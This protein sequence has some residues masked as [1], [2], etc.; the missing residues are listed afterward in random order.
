[1]KNNDFEYGMNLFSFLGGDNSQTLPMENVEITNTLGEEKENLAKTNVSKAENKPAAKSSKKKEKDSVTMV[2]LPI[3]CYGRNWKHT[4]EGTEKIA[5]EK[6]LESL[7]T[8]NYEEVIANLEIVVLS[9]AIYFLYPEQ[10]T[11]SDVQ[12]LFNGQFNVCDGLMQM[13]LSLEDFPDMVAEEISL[14]TIAEKFGRSFPYYE[15][16]GLY[17]DNHAQVAIPVF[18]RKKNP[19]EFVKLPCE[20]SLFGERVELSEEQFPFFD[21]KEG[22]PV[23]EIISYVLG[24]AP[25]ELLP[26]LY[27]VQD[28][29]YVITLT[30]GKK[31]T[32]STVSREGFWKNG[33]DVTLVKAKELIAL[34]CNLYFVTLN[35]TLSLTSSV[36]GGKTK[37]E[38]QEI[39]DYLKSF[40]S[41]LRS[42]DRKIEFIYAKEQNLVSIAL[43]SGT[44]GMEEELKACKLTDSLTLFVDS[45]GR[46]RKRVE[47][48]LLGTFTT[49]Y[50]E[51]PTVSLDYTLPLIPNDL[52]KEIIKEFSSTLERERIVQILWDKESGYSL[53]Y[54]R[55]EIASKVR[56]NYHFSV[57]PE[58]VVVATIHSHT[59][60]AA[61]FSKVDDR[62]ERYTGIFG[63]L[64][65]L[66]KKPTWT[67]RVGMEGY[68]S[69][70]DASQII[71]MKKEFKNGNN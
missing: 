27:E 55:E 41:V 20:V 16:K 46:V 37:V 21:L 42:K 24:E 40:Y 68:F 4:I 32:I 18:E 13:P 62:D 58:S 30:K 60:G 39:I 45:L 23:S 28:N 57:I 22:I 44:K 1:M 65:T 69:Q 33:K 43:I 54:P 2:Q 61:Y 63:V 25:K 52:W 31:T 56:I 66:H 35:T 36:F 71:M 11:D 10:A 29:R 6:V 3:T 15:N 49:I 8:A 7:R 64:G 38:Q 26:V 67:F 53:L 14:Y 70:I 19:D 50:G 17:L 9:R 12:V 5:L 47:C 34:P 48:T 59:T 51:N